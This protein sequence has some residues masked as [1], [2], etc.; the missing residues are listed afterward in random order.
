MK[1][2]LG[3]T[4]GVMGI[5]LFPL[6]GMAANLAD[7][8]GLVQKTRVVMSN[9][10]SIDSDNPETARF[11]TTMDQQLVELSLKGVRLNDTFVTAINFPQPARLTATLI[12]FGDMKILLDGCDVTDALRVQCNTNQCW[13]EN[14]AA[15][16]AKWEG[17]FGTFLNLNLSV[18]QPQSI[19]G[20]PLLPGTPFFPASRTQHTVEFQ[21]SMIGQGK[22]GNLN[23]QVII[24]PKAFQ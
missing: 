6:T 5:L 17:T 22:G 15:P 21:E 2:L 24:Y 13:D 11:T 19:A 14:P 1:K 12:N 8:M 10:A 3:P 7:L 16:R 18:L 23:Y 9:G 4:V 20:C